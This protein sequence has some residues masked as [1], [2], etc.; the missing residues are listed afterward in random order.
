MLLAAPAM[1]FWGVGT[2]EIGEEVFDWGHT[3]SATVL[4]IA[5]II[6]PALDAF[7]NSQ[8]VE[9]WYDK[10]RRL[11]RRVLQSDAEITFAA[12]ERRVWLRNNKCRVS[13]LLSGVT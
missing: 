7:L 6:I 5:T 3:L 10:V 12:L 11:V 1:F 4:A 9:H 13:N 2:S 8:S